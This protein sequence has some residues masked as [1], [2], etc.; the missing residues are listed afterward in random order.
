MTI[1]II[2]FFI[3]AFIALGVLAFAVFIIRQ[4]VKGKQSGRKP[5]VGAGNYA[6][7]GTVN[8]SDDSN[9]FEDYQPMYF[10]SNG[11]TNSGRS[12]AGAEASL[13]GSLTDN[14]MN[15]APANYSEASGG[16][17]SATEYSSYTESVYSD[18]STSSYDSPSSYSDSSSSYDSSSNSS[19]SDSSSSSS[20]WD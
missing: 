3:G 11:E 4:I 8:D 2:I 7:V 20:S 12:E 10:A 18:S 6:G 16:A 13:G 9:D 17:G 5:F 15:E 1:A 19:S 14:S